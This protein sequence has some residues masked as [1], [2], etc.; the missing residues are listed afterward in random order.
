MTE[1]RIRICTEDCFGK[2]LSLIAKGIDIIAY[3]TVAEHY[4]HAAALMSLGFAEDT[5]TG[6]IF[7]QCL[8]EVIIQKRTIHRSRSLNR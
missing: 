7:L 2:T 8:F 3:L 4:T 5:D 1:F 6:T